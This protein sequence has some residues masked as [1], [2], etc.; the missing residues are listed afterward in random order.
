[1]CVTCGPNSSKALVLK[2]RVPSKIRV[3]TCSSLLLSSC[4][5]LLRLGLAAIPPAGELDS[6]NKF[7]A[8]VAS[9][10]AVKCALAFG[11]AGEAAAAE[12]GAPPSQKRGG[13]GGKEDGWPEAA[14]ADSVLQL[15]NRS[16]ARLACCTQEGECTM[17]NF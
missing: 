6:D 14:S 1:M 7:A 2:I 13:G 8:A 11:G 5:M 10:A 15:W 16:F 12:G 4:L 9:S 3:L 17:R